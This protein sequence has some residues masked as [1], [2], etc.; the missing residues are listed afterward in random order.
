MC[1]PFT[2]SAIFSGEIHAVFSALLQLCL[3]STIVNLAFYHRLPQFISAKT[4]NLRKTIYHI[5]LKLNFVAIFYNHWGHSQIQI[6]FIRMDNDYLS[7]KVFTLKLYTA[8]RHQNQFKY[9]SQFWWS[10][11]LRVV[12][13]HTKTRQVAN[14]Q[15]IKIACHRLVA[16]WSWQKLTF[17]SF[18]DVELLLSSCNCHTEVW[19][20]RRETCRLM[21]LC[22]DATWPTTDVAIEQCIENA[23]FVAFSTF[24]QQ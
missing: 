21:R 23:F 8:L 7:F 24:K 12:L 18:A 19:N 5:E 11:C 1:F 14:S 10:R 16:D 3:D 15:K 6:W 22:V 20:L 13:Q 4:N 17:W 2:P 9:N